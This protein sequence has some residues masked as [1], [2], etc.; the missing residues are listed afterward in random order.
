MVAYPGSNRRKYHP[1][2]LKSRSLPMSQAVRVALRSFAT[3]L[4]FLSSP[5]RPL[6]SGSASTSCL[7]LDQ[8]RVV[9]GHA[10]PRDRQARGREHGAARQAGSTGPS[11]AAAVCPSARSDQCSVRGRRRLRRGA[12]GEPRGRRWR[13]R[14]T[15]GRAP[16]H[17][18]R[19]G[20][21]RRHTSLWQAPSR[22]RGGDRRPAHHAAQLPSV[23]ASVWRPCGRR[24][25][26]RAGRRKA[27][28]HPRRHA[29]GL[30]TPGQFFRRLVPVRFRTLVSRAG[31]TA[32]ASRG[33]PVEAW[34]LDRTGPGRGEARPRR[35]RADVSEP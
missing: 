13:S 20:G 14:G 10:V 1:V 35:V 32:L 9:Q 6:A 23:A 3:V 33:R 25:P 29:R 26:D 28:P 7:Q 2:V 4:Y 27:H 11:D 15:A 24:Q 12:I 34:S 21:V 16:D 5:W 8:P 22:R 18:D 19:P 30:R 31:D 17:G